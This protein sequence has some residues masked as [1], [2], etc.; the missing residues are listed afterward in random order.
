MDTQP[1]LTPATE[2]AI[3]DLWLEEKWNWPTLTNGK[4]EIA[5]KEYF[6]CYLPAQP[7]TTHV[8]VVTFAETQNEHGEYEVFGTAAAWPSGAPRLI[9]RGEKVLLRR[10]SYPWMN[11]KSA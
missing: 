9:H 11:L 4:V 2:Q 7:D 10:G 1:T 3:K 6:Q 5:K 8:A